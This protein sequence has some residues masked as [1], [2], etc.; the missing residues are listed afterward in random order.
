[1]HPPYPNPFQ[2]TAHFTIEAH[3][4]V[5]HARLAIFDMLGREVATVYEGPIDS[6]GM[7]I[8]FD[9]THLPAGIYAYSLEV[10]GRLQSG[11]ITRLHLKR[12]S[13]HSR[14]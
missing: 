4:P 9:G 8:A 11:M 5:T 3:E 2:S 14:C 12:F 7:P 10:D 13:S 1:M 6:G